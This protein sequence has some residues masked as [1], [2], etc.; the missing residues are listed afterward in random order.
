MPAAAPA[1]KK[2]PKKNENGIETIMATIS[3]CQLSGGESLNRA[4]QSFTLGSNQLS[5]I[6]TWP[7]T[8]AAIVGVIL[9]D[10]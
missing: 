1:W 10:P 4:S 7:A 5:Q 9:N 8:T 6:H 3:H 2:N